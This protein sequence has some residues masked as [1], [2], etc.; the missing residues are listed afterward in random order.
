VLGSGAVGLELGQVFAR[1]GV[2]V[3]VVE[4]AERLLPLEEP[5][6]GQAIAGVLAREGVEVRVGVR[7]VQVAEGGM[8]S[9]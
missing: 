4:A 6:A 2:R 3:N 5:E 7:V 1:F 8:A 9:L